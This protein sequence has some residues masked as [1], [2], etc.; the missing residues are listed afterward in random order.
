MTTLSTSSY[1]TPQVGG[2]LLLSFSPPRPS[3]STGRG[4]RG[5]P[6][7]RTVP[8]RQTVLVVGGSRLAAARALTCLE[9][10]YRVV[11]A[12]DGITPVD[13]ELRHRLAT[14]EVASVPVGAHADGEDWLAWLDG[15]PFQN[16]ISFVCFAE[17]G[18]FASS[19]SADLDCSDVATACREACFAR[20][21]PLNVANRPH[22]SDFAFPVTYR[23]PSS[24]VESKAPLQLAIA[25]S[26]SSCRLA[27]RLRREIVS[28]VSREAG[29]A[30]EAISEL[31]KRA[32]QLGQVEAGLEDPTCRVRRCSRSRRRSTEGRWRAHSTEREEDIIS[33]GAGS[34]ALNRP[35]T[36]L[37]HLV[38]KS[39]SLPMTPPLTPPDSTSSSPLL[40]SP[41]SPLPAESVSA[42]ASV[43][44]REDLANLALETR[45]R[46]IAQISEYWALDRI[47]A[48]VKDEAQM[49]KVLQVFPNHLAASTFP[50]SAPSPHSTEAPA[51]SSST[52]QSAQQ[53]SGAGPSDSFLEPA[54]S[55][56]HGLEVSVPDATGPTR[57]GRILLVGSGP[58]HPGLL[59]MAAHA[60]LTQSATVVLSD[61]LVPAEVLALVPPTTKLYIAKK[62]PGNAE[63]A[64]NEL[65]EMALEGAKNGEVVV[66]LK[67]GTSSST[68][69]HL[70]RPG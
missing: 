30:C 51:M 36:Q 25:T 65:M 17:T 56:R 53:P 70:P 1:A 54:A 41:L 66:R 68:L 57:R 33:G 42:L 18:F 34:H 29:V 39:S 21:I 62:Y 64:Q 52:S 5:T 63:G 6:A 48:L 23:W 22:L 46:W 38:N 31:R 8:A 58:G 14:G 26:A 43:A 19:S 4:R 37:S 20:R 28:K 49:A 61:K 24:E 67:Q 69:L 7:T 60:A 59:T 9:A 12:L 55:P 35:V 11:L 44:S 40:G 16:D 47:A 3:T 27:V 13:P 45:M 32:R 2:S 10:G 50:A 15:L